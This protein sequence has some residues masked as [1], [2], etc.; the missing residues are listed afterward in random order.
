[1]KTFVKATNE[2]ESWLRTQTLVVEHDLVVK[3]EKMAADEFQFFRA[4]FYR[5]AELWPELC[6]KLSKLVPV[7]GIGDLHI[8]NFGTWRDMEGRLV[9]GVNDFDEACYSAF[10]SDLV[11]LAVSAV[12]AASAAQT[13]SLSGKEIVE[14]ILDG[15]T[16]SLN[17]G[18]NPFVLDRD[19][20]WLLRL[21]PKRARMKQ[22]LEPLLRD[23]W[24]TR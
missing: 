8:Q 5:W 22:A 16:A 20:A 18:G 1:M 11:R 23:R 9:W 12:L 4:T 10:A 3:H 14:S 17:E 19:H 13:L 7:L 15:Y 24:W 21:A 6:P 2:F